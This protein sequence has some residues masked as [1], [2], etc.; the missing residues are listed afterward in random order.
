MGGENNYIWLEILIT[1]IIKMTMCSKLNEKDWI[2][3]VLTEK[4]GN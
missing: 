4:L 2:G 3:T 1:K